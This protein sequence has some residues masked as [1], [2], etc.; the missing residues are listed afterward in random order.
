MIF[1]AHKDVNVTCESFMSQFCADSYFGYDDSKTDKTFFYFTT[2]FLGSN[3]SES[4]RLKSLLGSY[5]TL[6]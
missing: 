3:V 5:T 1:N 2:S 6:N 4:S